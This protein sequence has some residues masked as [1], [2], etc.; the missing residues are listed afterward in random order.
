MIKT[1]IFDM[2]GL[3]FD[4]ER[5]AS[6]AWI[7]VGKRH[8]LPITEQL[9]NRMKGLKLED[10]V[11]IFREELGEDFDYWTLRKERTEYINHWIQEYGM[12]IKPGLKKLL[13]WLKEHDYP[14]ALATSTHSQKASHYLELA[15]VSGYFQYRVFGDMVQN[16]KPDPEIFLRAIKETETAAQQCLVLE[17]SYAGVEAGW[18]AGC[19]VIMVP[20]SLQPTERERGRIAACV[21]TLHEVI[22]WLE[23]DR[24]KLC[25]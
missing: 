18:R 15:G 1:V 6:E 14:I 22:L 3:M 25:S 12:P 20:D 23:R 24:T 21:K 8:G 5:L 10:C 19:Q 11:C 2:D 16:G 17:D 9:M 4:T 7:G 13:A